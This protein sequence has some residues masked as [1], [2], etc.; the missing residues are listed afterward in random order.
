MI[1]EVVILDIWAFELIFCFFTLFVCRHSEI[2]SQL[3][4]FMCIL[5][6]PTETHLNY[7]YIK[8]EI[9][10]ILKILFNNI[11]DLKNRKL[12]K[13]VLLHV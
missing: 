13:I 1:P 4:L 11:R 9:K 7:S 3:I 10:G 8:W 12:F 5:H 2:K 6:F